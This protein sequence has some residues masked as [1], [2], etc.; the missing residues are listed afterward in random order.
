MSEEVKNSKLKKI[1]IFCLKNIVN[2]IFCLLTVY[3]AFLEFILNIA[4]VEK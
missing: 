3:Y 2:V 4:P 1:T